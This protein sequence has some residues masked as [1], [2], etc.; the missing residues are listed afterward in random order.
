[1]QLWF[2]R[3]KISCCPS[4]KLYK[5]YNNCRRKWKS[6]MWKETI[7]KKKAFDFPHGTC[8]T[9]RWQSQ[10]K[11]LLQYIIK[12]VHLRGLVWLFTSVKLLK[13][14]SCKR[15]LLIMTAELRLVW[16]VLFR[17]KKCHER[18]SPSTKLL[19]QDVSDAIGRH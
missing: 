8:N 7:N 9:S 16:S 18:L 5:F 14:H 2:K 1:M 3:L 10:I 6:I 19:T 4:I 11:F 13:V 12:S 17:Q 15:T